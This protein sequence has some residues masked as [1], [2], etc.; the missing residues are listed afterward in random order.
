MLLHEV[1]ASCDSFIS[2]V[3]K[4]NTIPLL[5]LYYKINH[6]YTQ[7]KSEAAQAPYNDKTLLEVANKFHN[8]LCIMYL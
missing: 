8:Q 2:E 6:V 7:M 5:I 3:A 4:V 1:N